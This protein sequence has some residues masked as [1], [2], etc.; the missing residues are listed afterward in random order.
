MSLASRETLYLRGVEMR[1]ALD[2]SMSEFDGWLDDKIQ[3]DKHSNNNTKLLTYLV[4]SD[5]PHDDTITF[6][7][8]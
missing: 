2:D 8:P 4:L 3:T 7:R 5:E 1:E 6:L